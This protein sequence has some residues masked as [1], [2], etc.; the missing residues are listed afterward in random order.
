VRSNRSIA[1]ARSR[2]E[3]GVPAPRIWHS[4]AAAPATA[5]EKSPEVSGLG[6]DRVRRKIFGTEPRWRPR[7]FLRKASRAVET[8]QPTD[9]HNNPDDHAKSRRPRQ[10][11]PI[12]IAL[13]QSKIERLL[14][15]IVGVPRAPHRQSRSR[16]SPA[17]FVGKPPG[18]LPERA[19]NGRP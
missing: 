13:Y 9:Q 16:Y 5:R 12:S 17:G 10:R 3:I 15:A 11:L 19:D 7:S 1:S 4:A 18:R 8:L 2:H 14:L 6:E